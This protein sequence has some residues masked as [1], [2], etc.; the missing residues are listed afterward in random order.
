MEL[1]EKAREEAVKTVERCIT[2]H[3]LYAS[4]T[5]YGYTSVWARDSII[6][7]I[8]AC[9][10]K[11]PKI[12]RVFA[13]TLETL[14]KHQTKLG[15]IPNC[16]DL[17]DKKR[18][19]QVTFATLDSSCWF[20]L[21][22]IAYSKAYKTKALLKKHKKNIE[23]AFLWL[24]Y[25]DSGEDSLP[26]QQPTSDWQDAF[27][28]NYGHVLNTQALYYAALLNYGKTPQA[29]NVKLLVNHNK[30]IPRFFDSKKG[31]FAPYVWKDHAGIVERGDWFDSLA[32]S[33][34][35]ALGLAEHSKAEKILKH[36]E[37]KKIN[38]PFPLKSIFPPI[39]K[40]SK[41]WHEYFLKCDS[42]GPLMYSNGGI[43]PM[44]G[45]FYIASLVRQKKFSK[46]EKE[47]ELLAK[48][49]KQGKQKTWEFNEWLSGKTGKPKGGI[50]QAWSAGSFLFGYHCLKSKK[51]PFF[52]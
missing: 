48:A 47:L 21:G 38:R 49:N 13:K 10:E 33:L 6:T 2:P 22:H 34:S 42:K 25:Q 16:V 14:A 37:N 35:I 39:T 50:Y 23:L 40:K 7:L 18:K 36:I 8:G 29:K 43:W 32:N 52:K 31:F 19:H 26:E 17:F 51:I 11:N 9:S 28:H 45:G 4:G 41:Y 5:Y 27:P 44:I 1:I 20:L 12:Q 3:G 15:Q 46:A 30:R 24:D